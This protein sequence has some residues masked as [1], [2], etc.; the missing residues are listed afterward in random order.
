M[1]PSHLEDSHIVSF[2]KLDKEKEAL[3]RK[4]QGERVPFETEDLMTSLTNIT[5]PPP[6]AFTDPSDFDEVLREG[7]EY[8]SK[9][10]EELGNEGRKQILSRVE[11]GFAKTVRWEPINFPLQQLMKYHLRLPFPHA[12]KVLSRNPKMWVNKTPIL[13]HPAVLL[14][15]PEWESKYGTKSYAVDVKEGYI[16]AVRS[17]DWE[18][19]VGRA[20]VA[21]DEPLEIEQITP[22]E[23]ETLAGEVQTL[24]SKEK[25]PL[26]ESTRKDFREPIQKGKG[27]PRTDFLN[28]E[29]RPRVPEKELET[30]KRKLSFGDSAD[31][32]LLAKEIEKDIKDAEQ[33]QWAL[34]TERMQIEIERVTLERERQRIAEERLKAL[35]QQR[36]RLEESIMKMSNE[37]SKDINLV[38]E[39][40]KQR[41]INMENEYLNQID[42]EEAA[43][44]DF[45]PVL[46]RV[47][48]IQPDV[49]TTDS[50]ISSTVDPIEFMDEEAL[51]KLKLKHMRAEQCRTRTHKMYKLFLES[52]TDTKKKEN[53]EHMLLATINNLDRKMSKFKE[54]LDDYDQKEQH[55]LMQTERLQNEQEKALQEQRELQE[56]LQGLQAKHKVA[57]DELKALQKEKEDADEKK[58]EMEDKINKERKAKIWREQRLEEERQKLKDLE[59]KRKEK[60]SLKGEKN[61]NNKIREQQDRLLAERLMEKERREREIKDRN[62]AE[63]LQK[64]QRLEK[65]EREKFLTEQLL[66]KER[67][68]EEEMIRIKE[69]QEQLDREEQIR[70]EEERQ[71][72]LTEE[73]KRLQRQELERLRKEH[74]KTLEREKR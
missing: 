1:F 54:G 19:L 57:E 10:E 2:P 5:E 42:L 40:R 11:K 47:E 53:L 3:R 38:T 23:K 31:E 70:L 33:A 27:I 16:Y 34:E 44:D 73:Q 45:F 25:V 18:R 29:P 55:V 4:T 51:M 59:R 26:A 39:D 58:K 6:I 36:K 20:Y 17:E 7:D 32:E 63:Q 30:P 74:L 41:R 49:M 9:I 22:V 72:N 21:T 46:T 24:N 68:E 64:K 14:A 56:V 15:I 8:L 35:R 71:F 67:Q 50:Q 69:E 65:D 52:A 37:M 12:P 43:V 66:E 61:E 60:G 48:E 28:S 62:L 13:E